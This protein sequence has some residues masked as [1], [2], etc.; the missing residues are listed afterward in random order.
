M[1]AIMRSKPFHI[2]TPLVLPMV[3]LSATHNLGFLRRLR[4]YTSF[5]M[6]EET[7]SEMACGLKS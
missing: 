1:I 2:K 4:S 3:I 7:G 5:R 6:T